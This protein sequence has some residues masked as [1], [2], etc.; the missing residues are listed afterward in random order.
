[1]SKADDVRA[2]VDALMEGG[3]SR[4]EAFKQVAGEYSQPVN[5]IRSSYYT[6]AGKG[7]RTRRPKR[8]Q[9][10]P[11]DALADARASLER[12]IQA[13][14]LEV[15]V[16]GERADE[17]VREHAELKNSADERKQAIQ[18]RLDQLH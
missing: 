8:R 5:S 3:A 2:K 14:D 12:S 9:T 1:M 16:A 6:A 7:E 4:P 11:S 15:V 18:A 17:A 10:M 13:I